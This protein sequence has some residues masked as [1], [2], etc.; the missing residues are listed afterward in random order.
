MCLRYFFYA[1]FYQLYHRVESSSD[2][3][4]CEGDSVQTFDLTVQTPLVYN[5]A[6]G[7]AVT[8]HLS[9]NDANSGQNAIP[10]ANLASYNGANRSEERRVGKECRSRWSACH[11]K[12]KK[13]M[14]VWV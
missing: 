12:K 13:G 3:T 10:A 8:Y 4:I 6:S 7:Y 9:Q 2:L 14:I 11:D 5:N 1:F